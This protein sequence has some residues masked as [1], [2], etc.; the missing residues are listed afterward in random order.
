MEFYDLMTE[1]LPGRMSGQKPPV[2]YSGSRNLNSIRQIQI[3]FMPAPLMD[4][5]VQRMQESA[6]QGF[7]VQPMFPML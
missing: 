6:G 5:T 1:E 4:Y 7:S 2:N 3:F